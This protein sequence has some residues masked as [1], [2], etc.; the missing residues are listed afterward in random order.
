MYLK[1]LGCILIVAGSSL[2]GFYLGENLKKRLFQLKELEQGIYQL[3]SELVYTHSTLPEILQNISRK[4]TKP[5]SHIFSGVADLLYE[6]KADSVQDGFEKVIKVKR[7]LLNLKQQDIDI[8]RDLSK[9]LG[10][11]DIEG[12]KNI[13]NLTIKNVRNQI[14]DAEIAMK[15]NLKMYRYLGFSFGAIVVIMI[16]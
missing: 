7:E 4:C 6:N 3:Q 13:I 9:S 2:I 5:I 11:S 12:Q 1:L 14:D 16:L 15:N 10:E 8:L